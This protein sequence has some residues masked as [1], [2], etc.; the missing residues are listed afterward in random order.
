MQSLKQKTDMSF[1]VVAAIVIV[2]T[3]LRLVMSLTLHMS[4]SFDQSFDDELL[5]SYT[6]RSHFETVGPLTL[7]KVPGYSYWLLANSLFGISAD[8]AYYLMWWGAACAAACALWSIFNRSFAPAVIVYIY[9]LWNPIAFD[10]WLGLRLYRNSLYPPLMFLF[11]GLMLLWMNW[12]TPLVRGAKGCKKHRGIALCGYILLGI[13]LGIAMGLVYL[14]KEDS[15]WFLPLIAFLVVFKNVMLVRHRPRGYKKFVAATCTPFVIAVCMILVVAGINYRYFGVPL[16]NSRTSGEVAGFA[17]RV[18]SIDNPDQNGVIWAPKT[19]IEAAFRVSPTLQGNP[20]L[21]YSLE[22]V[23][24]TSPNI[25]EKPLKGDFLTWQIRFAY[26]DTYGWTDEAVI[27]KFFSQANKEI[28][29]AFEKG[30]LK[31]TSKISLSGM[32][33]PRRSAELPALAVRA[34]D[35][36]LYALNYSQISVPKKARNSRSTD[37]RNVAGLKRMRVDIDNP[38]PQP[39]P[40]FSRE[41]ALGLVR[42]IKVVYSAVNSVFALI[43]VGC[44]LLALGRKM[45]SGN[46]LVMGGAFCFLFYGWVYCFSVSWFGTFLMQNDD[47]LYILFF[48]SGCIAVPFVEMGLLLALGILL[49][50]VCNPTVGSAAFAWKRQE[51]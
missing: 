8:I 40:F 14:L 39:I 38:N 24:F 46:G 18:Y 12:Q 48:Y 6:L 47:P 32:L 51:A 19:S 10:S 34:T 5:M 7:A 33:V 17:S 37:P 15:V 9:V 2:L 3:L 31:K 25:D 22:H 35:L 29:A 21:L 50:A 41:S 44:G 45:P 30:T 27:Q 42:L 23:M 43:F 1:V 28:D 16:L 11:F 4:Y 36:W 49:S 20:K 13:S 26:E